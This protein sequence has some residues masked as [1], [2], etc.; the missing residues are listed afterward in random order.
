[1]RRPLFSLVIRFRLVPFLVCAGVL[2]LTGCRTY[3]NEKYETGP[4]TYEALQETVKQL[5]QE[6]GRAESELRRLESA[7]EAHPELQPLAER[8]RSYVESH[9][10]ALDGHREQAERLSAGSAYRTLHRVYGATVTDRHLLQKQ[11][12]RTTRKVWAT[13][14]DTAIPRKP[15]RDRGQYVNTPV[16][17][18]RVDGQFPIT[19]AEALRVLEGTPG[20]QREEQSA[21]SGE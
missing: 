9:E 19:M 3:G 4:K 8:Y 5:E 16:N 7:A 10:A 17:F 15:V 1:M 13:V 20:L 21:S 11:Y 12:R 2:L 18:P 6:L 14:R